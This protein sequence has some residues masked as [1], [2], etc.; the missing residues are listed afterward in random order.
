[1]N[2]LVHLLKNFKSTRI[3]WTQHNKNISRIFSSL[4]Q[5]WVKMMSQIQFIIIDITQD[6]EKASIIVGTVTMESPKKSEDFCLIT[7]LK[8]LDFLVLPITIG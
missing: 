8:K 7:Q 4:L 3:C 6:Y 5:I 1:M 2:M